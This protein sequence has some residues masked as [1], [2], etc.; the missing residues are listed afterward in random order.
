M[1]GVGWSA[2]VYCSWSG[3]GRCGAMV[4]VL[5]CIVVS[6]VQ[7]RCGAL[8]AVLQCIVVGAVREVVG[9]W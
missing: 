9:R 3:K 7:G 1:W 2:A 8:V 6:A 4:G 5:Q